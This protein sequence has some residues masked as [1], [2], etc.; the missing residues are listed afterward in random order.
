MDPVKKKFNEWAEN[1][2][3]ES[4]EIEHGKNVLKFLKK[5][6]FDK[7]FSFLDIG[8]GN[9]WVVRYISQIENCKTAVGIDV[10]DKMIKRA[11]KSISKNNQEFFCSE[12]ETWNTRKKFDFIFAMESIY[13]VESIPIALKKIFQ[14]LKPGGMFCCGTDFYSE[15][16]DTAKWQNMMKIRMHLLSENQWKKLFAEQGFKV[17]IKHI[18]DLKDGKKWKREL[19][20]LFI[21]GEK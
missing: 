1:G 13:Y 17:K 2:K 21:I 7:E 3:A 10:S 8:C 6:S 20:T 5:I 18:K 15:N 19:G 14:L 4:M 16:K 9:G 11:K 12:I